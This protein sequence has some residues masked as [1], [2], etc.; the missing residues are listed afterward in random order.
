MVLPKFFHVPMRC[1]YIRCSYEVQVDESLPIISFQI[2]G[3]VLCQSTKPL[4]NSKAWQGLLRHLERGYAA[5]ARVVPSC[6]SCPEC[7]RVLELSRVPPYLLL[8][9]SQSLRRRNR[10]L[11]NCP[12][13]M[14]NP[15]C[16]DMSTNAKT[17]QM[18][19][20]EVTRQV[21]EV[22]HLGIS[23]QTFKFSC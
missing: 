11:Q 20:L 10:R 22:V 23:Y 17:V 8:R 14:P 4:N 5:H 19:C 6:P 1:S 9:D 3:A 2:Q 18:C 16:L 12:G 15:Q 13:K 7:S 21:E